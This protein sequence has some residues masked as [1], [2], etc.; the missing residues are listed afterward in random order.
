MDD[1]VNKARE[2]L[3]NNK[4]PSQSLNNLSDAIRETEL[5]SGN[6]AQLDETIQYAITKQKELMKSKSAESQDQS[7]RNFTDSILDLNNIL[8]ASEKAF[9]GLE[10]IPRE[11][12]IDHVQQNVDQTLFLLAENLLGGVYRNGD[13]QNLGKIKY[14]VPAN[15][16]SLVNNS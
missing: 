7:S 13:F 9:W 11:Q 3:D 15:S 6:I 14:T 10:S 8:L 12:A 2:D 5:A 1:F 4:D 16:Q